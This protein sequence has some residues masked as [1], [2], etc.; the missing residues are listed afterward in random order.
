MELYGCLPAI[1]IIALILILA[2]ILDI[3]M[4]KRPDIGIPIVLVGVGI[5]AGI[6]LMFYASDKRHKRRR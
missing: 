6:C 4:K 5:L 3:F 2:G 1:I